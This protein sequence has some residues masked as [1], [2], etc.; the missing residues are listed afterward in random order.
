MH[1]Q[2]FLRGVLAEIEPTPRPGEPALTVPP[3]MTKPL[4]A[5]TTSQQQAELDAARQTFMNSPEGIGQ[6]DAAFNLLCDRFGVIGGELRSAGQT[7]ISVRR[8]GNYAVVAAFTYGI[9]ALWARS[10]ITLR[11]SEL[12]LTIWDRTPP[13]PGCYSMGGQPRELR[14]YTYTYGFVPPTRAAWLPRADA[15]SGVCSEELAQMVFDDIAQRPRRDP[16]FF[17][18]ELG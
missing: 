16:L 2:L 3:A 9:S 10:A 18:Q 14:R 4:S 8:H 5:V 11:D 6:A 15:L 13:F 12:R 1:V 7:D 17:L